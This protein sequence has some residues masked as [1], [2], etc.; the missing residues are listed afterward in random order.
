MCA[1]IPGLNTDVEY[2]FTVDVVNDSGVT[3]GTEIKPAES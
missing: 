3:K 1:T 2:F